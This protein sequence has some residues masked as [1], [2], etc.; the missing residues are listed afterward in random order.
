[1]VNVVMSGVGAFVCLVFVVA[2]HVLAPWW[3]SEAG[4][5]LMAFAGAVG[6]FLAYTVAIWFWPHGATASVLRGVRVTVSAAI[7]LLMVQRLVILLRVQR[8]RVPQRDRTGV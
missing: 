3:R 2:Y 8:G 7:I 5:N 4:R 6:A 1:M